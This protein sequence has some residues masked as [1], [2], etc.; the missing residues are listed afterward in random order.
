[1]SSSAKSFA[2]FANDVVEGPAFAFAFAFASLV[3]IP[4]GNLRLLFALCSLLFALHSLLCCHPSP[5]AEDMLLFAFAVAVASSC[6]H[7]E[8]SEGPRRSNLT[9]IARTFQP[10]SPPLP[11]LS[12][13]LCPVLAFRDQAWC[14]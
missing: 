11:S 3:V 9:H 10:T 5:Q 14:F 13:C 6:R 4:E 12:P 8:R 7:L 1:L 2:H